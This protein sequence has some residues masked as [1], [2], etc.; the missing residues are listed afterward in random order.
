VLSGTIASFHGKNFGKRSRLRA[1]RK[2]DTR[3]PRPA[4]PNER[5]G[6]DM[7]KIMIEGFG[8][9]YFLVVLDWHAKKVVGHYAGLQARALHWRS[10]SIAP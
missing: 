10:P 4:R 7:T 1:Q 3:K 6:I 8:W 2:A 9:V 5:W